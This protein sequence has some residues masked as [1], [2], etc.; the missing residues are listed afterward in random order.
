[1]LARLSGK[2]L[3]RRPVPLLALAVLSAA[4]ACAPAQA[5]E[6]KKG[7]GRAF[8]QLSP[9]A[10][11]VIRPDG[12]RGVV[13]METGV[14][15]KDDAT[16]GRIH[17]SLPRLRAAYVIALQNHAQGMGP[18]SAP[19]PDRLAADLQRETDR[20]LGKPGAKVLMGTLMIN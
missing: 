10:A 13:T 3:M 17:A 19:N 11:T 4:L 18:G 8:V 1:M 12:R 16:Y 20:V 14:D 5:S 6:K 7:G 9:L 15:A 2:T